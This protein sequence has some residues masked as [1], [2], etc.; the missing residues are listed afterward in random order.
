MN[1]NNFITDILSSPD[2]KDII[3]FGPIHKQMFFN[4]KNH[5]LLLKYLLIFWIYKYLLVLLLSFFLVFCIWKT[6]LQVTQLLVTFVSNEEFYSFVFI[7]WFNNST[8][9]KLL[10]SLPTARQLWY[11]L[12]HTFLVVCKLHAWN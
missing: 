10:N 11:L 6:L 4:H 3:L 12:L 1:S 7:T 9:I 8:R 5:P 2:K